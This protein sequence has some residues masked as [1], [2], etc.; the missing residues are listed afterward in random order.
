VNPS[1]PSYRQSNWNAHQHQGGSQLL[2]IPSQPH[3]GHAVRLGTR[4]VGARCSAGAAYPPVRRGRSLVVDGGRVAVSSTW[5]GWPVLSGGARSVRAMPSLR[6]ELLAEVFRARPAFA[7]ELL[8][9]QWKLALPEHDQVRLVSGQITDMAPTEYQADAVVTFHAAG[10]PQRAV[11]AVV[12]DGF[13]KIDPTQAGRYTEVVLAVLAPAARVH[14]DLPREPA[15]RDDVPRGSRPGRPRP[16]RG[17]AGHLDGHPA[18]HRRR[19]GRQP[20]PPVHG[21]RCHRRGAD[22]VRQL[23]RHRTTPPP[24]ASTSTARTTS[25]ASC[26]R[27]TTRSRPGGTSTTSGG[28]TAASAARSGTA[29]AATTSATCSAPWPTSASTTAPSTATSGRAPRPRSRRSSSTTR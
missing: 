23:L 20:D 12:V 5:V 21:R 9:E 7:A 19:R 27:R 25:T 16:D 2:Q 13:D 3:R 29:T 17:A 11:L 26:R 15:R 14:H 6:H 8:A 28:T 10:D 1:E 18:A 22:R 4:S 24:R